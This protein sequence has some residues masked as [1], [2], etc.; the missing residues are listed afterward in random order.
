MQN[1]LD[2]P[3]GPDSFGP[4]AGGRGVEHAGQVVG[5]ELVVSGGDLAIILK[6]GQEALDGV[7]LTVGGDVVGDGPSSRR[8]GRDDSLRAALRQTL[9]EVIGVIAA[10]G[11]QLPERPGG[12]DLGVDH[13]DVVGVVGAEQQHA[14]PAPVVHQ[15][16][17][18][19]RSAASGAAYA[20]EEGPPLAPAER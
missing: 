13:G 1:Q 19:G 8:G 16:V 14:G 20:L 12:L 9:P 10:I 18:L 6:P 15:P 2:E 11:Q 3:Y 5:R 17:D 4:V 7:E